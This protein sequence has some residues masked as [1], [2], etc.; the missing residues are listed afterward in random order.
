M[1]A[2]GRYR[3]RSGRSGIPV[4]RRTQDRLLGPQRAA[5]A[6]GERS[7]RHTT[8]T[9]PGGAHRC[10][11]PTSPRAI[12]CGTS[13]CVGHSPELM[14]PNTPHS[15]R[16]PDSSSSMSPENPRGG[17][18]RRRRAAAG[19]K[20]QP[21]A[22]WA[23]TPQKLAPETAASFPAAQPALLRRRVLS[24]KGSERG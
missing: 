12:T 13:N 11:S 7:T 18:S 14:H 4:L 23:R 15:S 16:I 8:L 6:G 3:F 19:S 24:K 22:R 9:L 21:A 1:H 2:T 10:C 20:H 17:R 5:W